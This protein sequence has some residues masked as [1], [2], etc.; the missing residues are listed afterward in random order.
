MTD[1]AD[2]FDILATGIPALVSLAPTR[3]GRVS[4]G[5]VF[6]GDRLRV[7]TLNI[8][9]GVTLAEHVSGVPVLIHVASGRVTMDI[10]GHTHELGQGALVRAAGDVVHE[11]HA[12]EDAQLVLTFHP[13]E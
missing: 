2:D 4:V 6:D 7:R 1:H 9:A 11:V 10:G 3:E 12:I 8:P 13:E 5:R